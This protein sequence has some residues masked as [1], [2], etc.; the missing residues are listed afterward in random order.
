MGKARRSRSLQSMFGYMP[1]AGAQQGMSPFAIPSHPADPRTHTTSPIVTGT[2]VLGLKYADGVLMVSD[3]LGSYGSMARF[4]GIERLKQFGAET[5]VGAGGDLSDFQYIE[6]LLT[7]LIDEDNL[8]HDGSRLD[9]NSIHKYLSRVMYNRRSKND[10]LWNQVVVGGFSK[11]QSFLAT[12]DLIGTQYEDDIIATG[13]GGHLALPLMREAHEKYGTSMTKEQAKDVLDNCMRVL[14]YRDCRALNK[15]Q[16]ANITA[17]GIDITP[18]GGAVGV[19][20]QWGL[21]AMVNPGGHD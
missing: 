6:E 21:K 8:H 20:T 17:D 19:S 1:P 14:F 3:T 15:L 18:I 11:G 5:V 10:P 16:F 2:S 13:Y 7:T 4:K 9:P 12:V